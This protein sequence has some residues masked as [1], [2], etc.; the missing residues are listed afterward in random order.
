MTLRGSPNPNALKYYRLWLLNR[1]DALDTDSLKV[2]SRYTGGP[3]K[4]VT[5]DSP[6]MG[7]TLL[8]AGLKSKLL[9]KHLKYRLAQ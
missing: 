2:T 5:E 7:K 8:C 3:C 4:G 6:L 9:R 1:R